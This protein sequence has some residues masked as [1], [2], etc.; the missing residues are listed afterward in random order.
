MSSGGRVVGALIYSTR[1]LHPSWC[2]PS[3]HRQHAGRCAEV[4]KDSSKSLHMSHFCVPAWICCEGESWWRYV[5]SFST[6]C[7]L[8]KLNITAQRHFLISQIQVIIFHKEMS[9][10]F[11]LC[12]HFIFCPYIFNRQANLKNS[13]AETKKMS[14]LMGGFGK[15]LYN[16]KMI[17][18]QGI[19]K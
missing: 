3:C 5:F 14:D 4:N 15:S 12:G 17:W 11:R 7:P 6:R 10:V 19:R 16:E 18:H 13:G 1:Q 9:F 8:H 2:L